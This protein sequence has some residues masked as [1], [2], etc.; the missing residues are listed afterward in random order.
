VPITDS[1]TKR[2]LLLQRTITGK[3]RI[4]GLQKLEAEDGEKFLDGYAVGENPHAMI[5]LEFDRVE[6]LPTAIDPTDPKGGLESVNQIE[7]YRLP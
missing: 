7:A 3:T 2:V 6:Y 5:G 4:V 1:T